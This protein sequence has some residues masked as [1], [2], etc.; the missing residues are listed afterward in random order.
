MKI[1]EKWSVR[2]DNGF[3]WWA[4]KNAQTIEIIGEEESPEG[5]KAYLISIRT[6]FLFSVELNEKNLK[7]I[8]TLMMPYAHMAGPVYNHDA[9]T[10]SLCSLVRVHEGISEWINPLISVASVLQ[11]GEV[12]IMGAEYAKLL[13]TKEAISSHPDNGV[14]SEPDEMAELIATFIAPMGKE[15]CKWSEDEFQ[16]TV[17]NYMQQPPSLMATNGGLGFTVEFPFGEESSLCRV[18]GE[19][20]HPRLGNGLLLIQSFP[21]SG[22]TDVEGAKLA[23]SLNAAEL[24][25]KPSGYGFGSYS[26]GKNLIH[27]TS[28]YPN[29]IY[30]SGLLV[31]IYYSC[32]NR[33]EA[34]SIHLEESEWTQDSFDPKRSSIGK[35]I[36]NDE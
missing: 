32:A 23:L 6:D 20:A 29:A 24:T 26:Y 21:V 3:E 15:P 22:Y 1:D 7:I 11:I 14:R 5:E 17:D 31:N 16:E 25:E 8:N 30:R 12:R 19:E 35:Q 9:K 18:K 4:D 27:F 36:L 2:N 13:N 33:A 34:M 10:L 28:F